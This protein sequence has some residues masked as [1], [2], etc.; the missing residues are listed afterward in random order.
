LAAVKA[1]GVSTRYVLGRAKPSRDRMCEEM[2]K[3][4][5]WLRAAGYDT[6][7]AASS[8]SETVCWRRREPRTRCG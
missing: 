8:T 6:A 2:L 3:G 5:R 7:I 1:G 4:G